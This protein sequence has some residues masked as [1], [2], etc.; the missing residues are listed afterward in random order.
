MNALTALTRTPADAAPPRAIG[1]LSLSVGQ[2]NGASRIRTLRQSGSL[3]ALF[4]RPAGP[5][6]EAVAG[7]VRAARGSEERAPANRR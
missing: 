1:A 2:I 7:A 3:K 6:L 5:A 4:P